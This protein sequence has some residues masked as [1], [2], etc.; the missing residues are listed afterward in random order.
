MPLPKRA[1]SCSKYFVC[2]LTAAALA[3][4]STRIA[5]PSPSAGGQTQVLASAG[6]GVSGVIESFHFK[7]RRSG[8]MR[9]TICPF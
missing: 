9:N 3:G 1:R 6:V 2:N 4:V 8:S 7:A 5:Y